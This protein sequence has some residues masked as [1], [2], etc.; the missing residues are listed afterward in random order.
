MY[1]VVCETGKSTNHLFDDIIKNL[2]ITAAVA[3][4]D[5]CEKS[6]D[7]KQQNSL[8]YMQ[9]SAYRISANSFHPRI[10]SEA[11]IQFIRQ[12]IE[13]CGNY[14]NF[15]QFQNSKKNSFRGNYMSK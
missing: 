4:K 3:K 6:H 2:I 13:I 10:L 12:Q 14:L 9:I 1:I 15:L 5:R 7:N 8:V 11:K